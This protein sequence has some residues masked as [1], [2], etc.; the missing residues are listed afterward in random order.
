MAPTR[1]LPSA[2]KNPHRQSSINQRIALGGDPGN[3]AYP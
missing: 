3:W 2:S 1:G